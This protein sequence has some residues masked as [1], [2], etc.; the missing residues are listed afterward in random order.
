MGAGGIS[1][2]WL[3]WL[4]VTWG[5][6]ALAAKALSRR[7]A[8]SGG[9]PPLRVRLAVMLTVVAV[10]SAAS[11]WLFDVPGLLEMQRLVSQGQWDAALQ[12]HHPLID[13]D[14]MLMV[15]LVMLAVSAMGV[16]LAARPAWWYA[17][18]FPGRAPQEVPINS[19]AVRRFRVYGIF[20]AIAGAAGTVVTVLAF[21]GSA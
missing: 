19:G 3:V 11:W 5:L 8:S 2:L 4:V 7:Y 20:I 10:T 14:P 9:L 12:A 21:L 16:H 18:G 13:P 6:I 15:P 1:L 17:N